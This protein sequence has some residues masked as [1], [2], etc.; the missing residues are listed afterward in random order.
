MLHTCVTRFDITKNLENFFDFGKQGLNKTV[1]VVTSSMIR[2]CNCS[3]H[4]PLFN[5]CVEY[6]VPVSRAPQIIGTSNH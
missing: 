2:Y 5:F 3:L 6:D 4:L 1:F